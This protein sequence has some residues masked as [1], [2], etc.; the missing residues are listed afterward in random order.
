MQPL[1]KLRRTYVKILA[2]DT[3]GLH[4]NAAITH[5]EITI[6]EISINARVGEKSWTHSEILMP[7]IQ[8]LFTLTGVSKSG[9]DYIAFTCGPGSFTGLRIGAATALGLA[10]ALQR[11]VIPVPTL[12]ALAQNISGLMTS[13]IIVPMM[14][15]RRGQVYTA[16]Y[17]HDGMRTTDYM[18]VQICDIV[19]QVKENPCVLTLGDGACAYR[20]QIESKASHIIFAQ[21][22]NMLQRAASVAGCAMRM[23]NNGL[24]LG[25]DVNLLYVRAPQAEQE[26]NKKNAQ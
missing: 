17:N 19:A 23:L 14:D 4:A 12:D 16:I 5:N 1:N 21:Q 22:N 24:E 26:K 18:A 3:S 6:G 20:S 15:A 9:I 10:K 7:S 25:S 13:G 11:P 2:I 8:Q